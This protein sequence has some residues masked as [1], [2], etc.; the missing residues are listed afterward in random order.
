[1]THNMPFLNVSSFVTHEAPADIYQSLIPSTS[2]FMSVYESEEADVLNDRETNAKVEFLNQLYSE[3]FDEAL[4]GLV[5]EASALYETRFVNEQGNERA[6]DREAERLLEQHFAPL[7]AEAQAMLGSLAAELMSWM[8]CIVA[9]APSLMRVSIAATYSAR[10]L[11]WATC[12]LFD[13]RF[14]TAER[15]SKKR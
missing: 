5:N 11:P 1:M 4:F 12:S 9:R 14:S 7:V 2:P 13:L 3:E 10:P 15:T 6:A 8:R